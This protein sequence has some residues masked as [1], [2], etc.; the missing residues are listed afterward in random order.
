MQLYVKLQGL[1]FNENKTA[2]VLTVFIPHKNMEDVCGI[3]PVKLMFRAT[4][5]IMFM[6][7]FK[8]LIYKA[9]FCKTTHYNIII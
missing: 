8:F 7:N 9:Y 5:C 4:C 6:Y 3:T 2:T 1:N